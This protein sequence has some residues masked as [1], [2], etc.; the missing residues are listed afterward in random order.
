MSKDVLPPLRHVLADFFWDGHDIR[1]LAWHGDTLTRER[2][3]KWMMQHTV[4]EGGAID[5]DAQTDEDA[6]FITLKNAI[7][8]IRSGEP[9]QVVMSYIKQHMMDDSDISEEDSD[10]DYS[11]IS[12]EDSDISEEDSDSDI[13][14][15][16]SDLDI[17]EEDSDSD[18][19]DISEE[20][21]GAKKNMV[22]VIEDISSDDDDTPPAKRRC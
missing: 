3:I 22:W 12:E 9:H 2:T 7:R 11:D 5:V 17:S 19:S 21:S 15:E 16:D 14:E 6:D 20:D 4:G 13:S 10:S 8:M 1:D 18:I